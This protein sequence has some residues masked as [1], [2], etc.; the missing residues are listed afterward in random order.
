MSVTTRVVG[1]RLRAHFAGRFADKFAGAVGLAGA[2]RTSSNIGGH[3]APTPSPCRLAMIL[4]GVLRSFVVV[5]GAL[6]AAPAFAQVDFPNRPITIY[7]PWPAGGSTDQCM[8]AFGEAAS[9]HLKTPVII[10]NRPGAGGTLGPIQL[11]QTG[12]PDGYTLSQMPMGMFRIPHMQPK[13]QVNSL[14]DFTYIINLTGYTFG[15][16]VRADAPWQTF[17]EFLDHA[18]ANPGKVT[19]G[20]T[21]TGTSPHLLMEMVAQKEGIEFLHV[22]F[23]GNADSTTALLGGHIMAQSDAT[24]WGPQVDAGKFRLLVTFGGARTKRWPK[25]PTAQELGLDIVSNSPYGIVAPKGVDAKIVATLHEGFKK[26]L[27]DPV[28]LAALDKYDQE[29][30]YMGPEAYAKWARATFESER[31]LIG[32]LGLLPK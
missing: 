15:M 28:H 24:G 17:R 11:A 12:K 10:E 7:V 31:A 26:A 2:H 13:F 5:L 14:T 6:V 23:K 8:R 1:V 25:V 3:I 29:L 19:Y 22:P 16:V 9:R 21:G 4:S 18:K 30:F 20:S 32:R 27:E